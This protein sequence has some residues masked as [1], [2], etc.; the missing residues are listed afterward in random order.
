MNIIP[1]M[2]FSVGKK[3]AIQKS[4]ISRKNRG[5][6]CGTTTFPYPTMSGSHTWINLQELIYII[7]LYPFIFF[8]Y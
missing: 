4:I 8:G 7:G 6:L 1:L 2:F 3:V 5:Y